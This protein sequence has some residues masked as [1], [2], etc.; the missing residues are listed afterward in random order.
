MADSM[1]FAIVWD[2]SFL[3]PNAILAGVLPRDMHE[4]AGMLF[5]VEA[6][7]LPGGVQTTGYVLGDNGYGPVPWLVVP[8]GRMVERNDKAYFDTCHKTARNVVER[9][10]GRLTD[11]WR[12]LLRH[13]KT[14]MDNMPQQFMTVCIIHNLLID[15]GVDFDECLLMERDANGIEQLIDMH[16]PAVP[17]SQVD[18]NEAALDLRVALTH[19]MHLLRE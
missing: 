18:A 15:A 9:V 3:M 10:F 4:E 11:M 8:Y 17:M 6:V 5:T 19:C 13:H 16:E 2:A 7:T 14:N 1:S 12:L